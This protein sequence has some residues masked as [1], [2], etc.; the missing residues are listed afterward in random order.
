MNLPGIEFPSFLWICIMIHVVLK[1]QHKTELKSPIL[2]IFKGQCLPASH[3]YPS[4]LISYTVWVVF[5]TACVSQEFWKDHK[6]TV[7]M[8]PSLFVI[9]WD[10]LSHVWISFKPTK[11]YAWYSLIHNFSSK[12]KTPTP[13][14]LLIRSGL[15]KLPQVVLFLF[16]FSTVSFQFPFL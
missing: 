9:F 8:E 2:I 15:Y 3:P 6:V 4:D 7:E 14:F 1:E 13:F 12:E 11:T 10:S 16:F 5:T